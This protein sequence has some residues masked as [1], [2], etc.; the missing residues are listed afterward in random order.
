MSFLYQTSKHYILTQ[1]FYLKSHLL[2]DFVDLNDKP[3]HQIWPHCTI[4]FPPKFFFSFWAIITHVVTIWKLAAWKSDIKITRAEEKGAWYFNG[5]RKICAIIQCSSLVNCLKYSL[6]S[7]VK[8]VQKWRKSLWID[9]LIIQKVNFFVDYALTGIFRIRL[10]EKYKKIHCNKS[11]L[12]TIYSQKS[13]IFF[14]QRYFSGQKLIHK[15]YFISSLVKL[16]YQ[17]IT[18]SRF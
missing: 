13:W 3:Q 12:T 6:A 10:K 5:P 8:W 16:R 18:I 9:K 7:F 17:G 15:L 11:I 4:S 2:K 14:Q 1:A